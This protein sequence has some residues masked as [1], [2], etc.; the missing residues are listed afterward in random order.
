MKN[1]L[2]VAIGLLCCTSF[3]MAVTE[4]TIPTLSPQFDLNIPII[5]Y[6]AEDN[7]LFFWADLKFYGTTENGEILFKV[8]KSGLVDNPNLTEPSD[9]TSEPEE[10]SGIVQ[11]HNV[12][13]KKV[14]VPNLKWSS[15]AAKIAQ[16]WANSLK[17]NNN[18]DMKHNP[19]RGNF[20][21]NIFWSKGY[22]PTTTEVV[23]SWGEEVDYYNYSNNTC[24]TGKVCGHYTQVVWEDTKEVGCGKVSCDGREQIWVC[25]YAP[26]GNYVGK[27][28]Y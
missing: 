4:E 22:E 15:E 12:W 27:K 14:G 11:A 13:R 3:V 1:K 7:P 8:A 23:D 24:Q 28:P 26:P 6:T 17:T 9:T 20:G 10:F 25:N 16:S 21:E 18:C 2:Y 5:H 19:D